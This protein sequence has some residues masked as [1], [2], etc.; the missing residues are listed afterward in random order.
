MSRKGLILALGFVAVSASAMAQEH[1][2]VTVSKD[3]VITILQEFRAEHEINPT[4]SR[5]ISL[6]K[7]VVDKSK[8]TRVKRRGFRVQIYAGSNRNEAYAIQSR[9]KNQYAD[10]DSYINYDEPNYRV[11]VGDFTSRSEANSFMRVLRA[12]Y[13][14]VFVF[15]EDI[16]VWE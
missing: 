2:G 6:G 9:F 8:A 1:Q 16:W 4:A 14:N 12:Q 3:S 7:R 5:M 13:S 15:Q 10:I 11:K